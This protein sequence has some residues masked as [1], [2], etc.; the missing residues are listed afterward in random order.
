MKNKLIKNDR[1]NRLKHVSIPLDPLP[2]PNPITEFTLW[3][4]RFKKIFVGPTK[5]DCERQ[6][7]A[8]TEGRGCG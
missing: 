4:A 3:S 2:N 8:Y 7:M 1:E 5:A 6:L